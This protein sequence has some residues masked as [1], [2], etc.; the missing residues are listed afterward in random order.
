M[1]DGAGKYRRLLD[2]ATENLSQYFFDSY[3]HD[4]A[5]F[6]TRSGLPMIVIREELGDCCSWCADLAGTYDYADAPPEVWQRHAHCRCMVITRTEKGAWQ[7]AWSRKEYQSER[8]ARIAREEELQDNDSK[9]EKQFR[10]IKEQWH[11]SSMET[12]TM[13]NTWMEELGIVSPENIDRTIQFFKDEIRNKET[14][15]AIV[16]D[17]KGRI[18][19]F[20]GNEQR[21][22]LGNV[23]LNG[24]VI[25]HNHPESNG[26]LSFGKDDIDLLTDNP[27]VILYLVNRDYDYYVEYIKPIADTSYG[28]EYDRSLSRIDLLN[29]EDIQHLTMEALREKGYVQYTRKR[30]S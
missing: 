12:G 5:E 2:E 11:L 20:V 26:I 28:M 16:I 17:K 7:D 22:G 1:S 14:E 13:D 15:H 4:N 29:P 24:A 6:R 21:V 23:D 8:E 19:H 30:I 3:G 25:L 18:Y 27:N 10:I 9:N